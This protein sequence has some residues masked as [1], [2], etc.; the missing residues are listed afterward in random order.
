MQSSIPRSTLSTSLLLRRSHRGICSVCARPALWQS[1][2]IPA[3]RA[4]VGMSMARR[5]MATEA[6]SSMDVGKAQDW[7]GS[8]DQGPLDR[9]NA[10][11]RR[12]LIK[13]DEYQRGI[14]TRLQTLHDNL[15]SYSPPPVIHPSLS[16]LK[17]AGGSILQ[18]IF[19]PKPELPKDHRP[20]GTPKGMYLYGDVGCGKTFLMDMFYET[21]P[22]NITSKARMHFHAF[23]LDVHKR[24]FELK[25][26]HGSAFD[27]IP[28]VA[29]D[30]AQ[31]ARVL[32]FDEFQVTDIVD[33][34]ILRRLFGALISHGVVVVTTSNRHPTELYKNGIQRSSFIP[35]IELLQEDLEVVCLD[36]P[37]DYRKLPRKVSSVYYHPLDS[38]APEHAQAWFE[39]LGDFKN[40]PPKPAHVTIWGRQVRVP[41]ASGKCAKFAFKEICG[42]PM[43]ASD[44]LELCRN[45]NAFV[46]TDVPQ[47]TMREKDLARRLIT[48]IDAV[49]D[50]HAK[51]VCTSAAPIAQIFSGE[52][53][54]SKKMNLDE[55]EME[56]EP[57]MR[58]LMDD[59]GL[60][61]KTLMSSSIFTGD[62]ERFAFQRC[63]SRLVQMGT[64]EW[65]GK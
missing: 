12:G 21:L 59:L 17:P 60:D 4:L 40:D 20:E 49:Y 18:R 46:I 42:M 9:Y 22:A 48:F 31:S 28:F 47:M 14:V 61:A 54:V 27:A 57:A 34:M 11:S 51:L 50:S 19:G 64:Q 37:T 63:I 3:G 44:Y 55:G 56:I 29:A 2:S 16:S 30:I 23:M 13:N 39:H 62:E 6:L 25:Q 33:A 32:C 53:P 10:L 5:G 58:A 65:V 1:P 24:S 43:S 38:H 7:N 8:D 26:Q 41:Q 45:F 52:D 15:K 36:S 35:C